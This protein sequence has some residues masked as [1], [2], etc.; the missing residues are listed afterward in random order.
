[1]IVRTVFR[2]LWVAVAF[3][4]AVATIPCYATAP[5]AFSASCCSPAP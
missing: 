3:C 4:L 2:M 1:M 5:T